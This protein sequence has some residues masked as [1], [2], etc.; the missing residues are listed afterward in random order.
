M[1]QQHMYNQTQ[2]Q[3][4]AQS[5][6]MQNPPNGY[7]YAY[8]DDRQALYDYTNGRGEGD[9]ASTTMT[10]PKAKEKRKGL[11]GLFGGSKAGRLA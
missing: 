5:M 10:T 2:Q 9:E 6:Y 8:P 4:M 11:K 3:R 1:Q 7:G